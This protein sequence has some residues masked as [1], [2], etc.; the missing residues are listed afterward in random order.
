[1]TSRI[2]IHEGWAKAVAIALIIGGIIAPVTSVLATT[3]QPRDNDANSIL[4]GGC[5]TKQ[6]CVDKITKGDG[7]HTAANIQHIYYQEGRG[8]TQ[9]SFMSGST[10]DGTVYKDGRVVVNGQTVATGAKSIG[11]TNM[12]GSVKSGTVY[13]RPTS[14]SFVANSIPAYVNMEGGTFHYFII[15][16]CGNAGT[17][18]PVKKPTPSPSPS[19]TPTPTPSKSPSPSPSKSPTPTPTP[20]PSKS[21]TPSPSPSKSP[22]PTPTPTH[23]P[24]PSPSES[25]T[26]VITSTPSATPG[27]GEVLGATLPQAGPEAALGGMAGLTGIGLASRAYLRSRKDLR[28]SL[29]KKR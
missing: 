3:A 27:G 12:P 9:A 25:P 15:K 5:Y 18:T 14:V 10:V 28:N 26:P 2:R 8:I 4:W 24:S 21:P 11:R 17:G 29:R 6:E 13:E 1:M 22:S 16:S 19:K 7:H 20:S 23:T